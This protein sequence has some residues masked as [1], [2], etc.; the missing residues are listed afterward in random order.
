MRSIAAISDKVFRSPACA[1]WLAIVA[2]AFLLNAIIPPS[3]S[4]DENS[5]L[6]RAYLLS[7]GHVLLDR[8]P[9]GSGGAIDEGL[10]PVPILNSP[11]L[12]LLR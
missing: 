3:Q 12:L 8:D 1:I 7:R 2:A 10:A 4:P 5:H 11:L 9:A 6:A